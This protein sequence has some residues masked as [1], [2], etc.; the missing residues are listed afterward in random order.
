MGTTTT[1][2]DSSTNRSKKVSVRR[3]DSPPSCA[4]S[5]VN[6]R[7]SIFAL[8]SR[9]NRIR[10][11]GSCRRMRLGKSVCG[12]TISI[13]SGSTPAVVRLKMVLRSCHAFGSTPARPD[14]PTDF[15]ETSPSRSK[16]SPASEMS[17]SAAPSELAGALAAK[18]EQ[19]NKKQE[20]KKE[21]AP[22]ASELAEAPMCSSVV[23]VISV[24]R[25]LMRSSMSVVNRS[26]S[27]FCFRK[28]QRN[29]RRLRSLLLLTGGFGSKRAIARSRARANSPSFFFF[30]STFFF[31]TSFFARSFLISSIFSLFC[32]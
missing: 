29:R 12:S 19:T 10:S 20:K 5:A 13:T 17:S 22:L 1:W 9:W 32:F 27:F 24:R 8:R 4:A 25:S 7:N 11:T 23:C 26:L 21:G 14:C 6:L 30:F 2:V 3:M 28:N 31:S 16:Q 18:M 15:T